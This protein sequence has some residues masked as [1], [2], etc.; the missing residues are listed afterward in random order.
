MMTIYDNVDGVLV[1]RSAP[2]EITAQTVWIDLY[3]PT[4]EED[5]GVEQALGVLVPT[6]EEMSEIE[7][8]SRLYHEGGAHVMTAIILSFA[9]NEAFQGD[10]QKPPHSNNDVAT[11]VTFML[12]GNRL[13]TVRYAEQ[14][15][16]FLWA[17]GGR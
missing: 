17:R 7:A 9:E 5:T 8:S 6:R 10:S 13:I 2:A 16:S 1:A 14:A 12:A 3:R 15:A 11:P 4:R